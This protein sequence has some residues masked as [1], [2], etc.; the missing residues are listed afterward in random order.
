MATRLNNVYAMVTDKRSVPF[1]S[2]GSGTITTSGITVN[3]TSTLFTSEMKAGSWLVNLTTNECRRV[4]RVDSDTRAYLE[5]AFT[6]DISVAAAP[7]IIPYYD[8]RAFEISLIIP[9]TSSTGGTNIKG[10]LNGVYL[11]VGIA[12]T[13]GRSDRA[14]SSKPDFIDPIVIDGTGTEILVSVIY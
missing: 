4:V 7:S 12:R 10:L 13:I 3:G 6:S 5:G 1:N 8:A 11:P 9:T 14:R 2:T